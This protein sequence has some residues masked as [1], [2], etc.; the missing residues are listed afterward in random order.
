MKLK[1]KFLLIFIFFALI[2]MFNNSNCFAITQE[3]LETELGYPLY[4]SSKFEYLFDEIQNYEYYSWIS[5]PDSN[6]NDKYVLVLSNNKGNLN[7]YTNS[8][9]LYLLDDEKN[10]LNFSYYRFSFS[11]NDNYIECYSMSSYELDIIYAPNIG[12]NSLDNAVYI[13][14]LDLYDYETN[15]ILF[16]V[17]PQVKT[18]EE[19]V[20]ESHLVAKEITQE[21]LTAELAELIPVGVAIMAAMIVVSLIAYFQFWKV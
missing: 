17:P 5:F 14:N 8:K 21:A 1:N 6:N 7:F 13:S 10:K 11:Q 16:Q 4:V 15:E 12:V 18:L 9:N 20:Q 2:L 19:V 3:E